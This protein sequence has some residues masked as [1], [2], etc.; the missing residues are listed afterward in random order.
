ELLAAELAALPSER[1]A[2]LVQGLQEDLVRRNA[3]P[4]VIQR[5]VGKG[6]THPMVRHEMVSFYAAG[7]YGPNWN[8]PTDKELLT[9]AA[10]PTA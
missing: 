3:H 4:A 9:I 6:W 5:L 8:K 7:A 2:E 10:A 1:Q